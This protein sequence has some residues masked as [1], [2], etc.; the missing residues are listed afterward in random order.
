MAD[1]RLGSW[2]SLHRVTGNK[3]GQVGQA[4]G[5]TQLGQLGSQRMCH[6]WVGEG[7]GGQVRSSGGGWPQTMVSLV[8]TA[9]SLAWPPPHHP[10]LPIAFLV[11]LP[12]ILC[13]LHSYNTWSWNPTSLAYFCGHLASQYQAG[14]SVLVQDSGHG[15]FIHSGYRERCHRKRHLTV[16]RAAC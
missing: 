2:W 9:P 11:T 10:S 16:T 5:P 14:F 8:E 15:L 6:A 4:R 12:I 13:C 1:W 3:R 7:R